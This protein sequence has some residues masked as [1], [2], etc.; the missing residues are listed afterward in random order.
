MSVCGYLAMYGTHE[1]GCRWRP[2][3]DTESPGAGSQADVSRHKW[4]L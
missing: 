1:R 4:L 3:W 2:E